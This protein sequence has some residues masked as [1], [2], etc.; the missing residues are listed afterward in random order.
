[1]T[2][3]KIQEAWSLNDR[4]FVVTGGSNGIGLA[5]V[6][7][8]LANG[9]AGVLFCSRSPCEDIVST[10]RAEYTDAKILHT[11]CDVATSEGREDL[12]KVAK[13]SFENGKIQGL[14]NN[15]GTNVRKKVLEQKE[16]EYHKMMRTN[17]DSAYFLCRLF[18]G[19]FDEEQGATIVNVSSAAGT[20]SSG[21]G[22]A[23][24]MSKAAINHF[25]KILACE[26]A[27]RNIRVNAVT[28][29]MTMTPML[30]EAVK[31]NPTQLDK[32]KAWTPMH[33][34]A[35]PDEVA[36]PIIFLCL[37]ASSYVTGQVLGVDGGLT[38]QGF[39]GPCVTDP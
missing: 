32:V 26:W 4:N 31:K 7:A 6:K 15:V 17:V 30:E 8:L 20:Q 3:A 25:T 27:Q 35:S 5:T 1:M 21:T 2:K 14:I 18:S 12:F 39:D 37:P 22:A 16:E 13:D 23:Y 11:I 19:L 38:A 24:G 36:G 10:L 34:L 33:R 28:P 29:W 9:A